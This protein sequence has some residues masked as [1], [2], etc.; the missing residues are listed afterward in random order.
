M[1]RETG[2]TLLELL[3]AVTLLAFLS[4][5]LMA[6]LRFGTNV[7]QK[8]QSKNVDANAMRLAQKAL[9][10]SLDRAYPKLVVVSPD[11]SHIDFDGIEDRMSFLE[12]AASGHIMRDT[13]GTIAAGKDLVLVMRAGP[14]LG[15][16]V[17]EIKLLR[18]VSAVE[19][20]YFGAAGAEKTSSW[21]RQWRDQHALPEMIRI[22][23]T[24]KDTV[25]WP[26]LILKPR[27]A[28]DASCVYDAVTKFCRGR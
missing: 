12:T 6:G 23:A 26:E 27:I 24:S 19:F 20:A 16:A 11:E 7:W 13:L 4:V 14:E 2:F 18:H 10:E 5:G 28:A 21:H 3:V 1:R 25:P 9:T 17:A 15:G 8:S 22:R